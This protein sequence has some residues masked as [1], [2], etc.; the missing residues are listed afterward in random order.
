MALPKK[1]IKLILQLTQKGA[2]PDLLAQLIGRDRRVILDTLTEHGIT[3]PW[4]EKP[5]TAPSGTLSANTRTILKERTRLSMRQAIDALKEGE[6]HLNPDK[7]N[8]LIQTIIDEREKLA[9]EAEA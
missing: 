3:G 9:A 5:H 1:E 2:N 6:P 8:L 7:L 4:P